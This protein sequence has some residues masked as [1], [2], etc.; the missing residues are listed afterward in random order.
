MR[1]PPIVRHELVQGSSV[2]TRHLKRI[3]AHG[4]AFLVR[5]IDAA[6]GEGRALRNQNLGLDDIDTR[7]HFGNRM[8]DLDARIDF[9]EVEL[10]GVHIEQKLDGPRADVTDAAPDGERGV[11]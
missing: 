10:V 8:L 1:Y 7:G 2:V 9:D 4:D 5:Q 11:A 3:A 6:V